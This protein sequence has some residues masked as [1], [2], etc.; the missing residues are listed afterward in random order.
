MDWVA[1]LKD[2]GLPITM[3]FGFVALIIKGWLVPG[4]THADVKAQRDR[5]LDLVFRMANNIQALADP[6]TKKTG[7]KP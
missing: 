3:L 2:F 1:I 7:G 4:I 5:A 6:D